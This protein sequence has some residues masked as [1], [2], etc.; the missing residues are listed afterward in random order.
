MH[1]EL[2]S[3]VRRL[4]R[5]KDTSC[6]L[7]VETPKLTDEEFLSF[8]KLIDQSVVMT[9]TTIDGEP[10]KETVVKTEVYEKTPSQRLHGVLFLL[11]K[12]RYQLQCKTFDEFYQLTMEKV[13]DQFK[14]LLN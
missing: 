6:S 8:C 1:F 13:I 4:N 7:T 11:W 5:K 3:I 9:L 12:Q 2:K 10:S 14:R